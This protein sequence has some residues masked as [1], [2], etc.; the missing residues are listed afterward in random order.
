[1]KTSDS[2]IVIEKTYKVKPNILWTA[3][4][5]LDEMRKWYFADLDQFKPEI[6]SLSKFIVN[7]ED[8][9]YTH[10]WE[11]NRVIPQE[12]ISY[13]W[14]FSEHPGK[15]NTEFKIV[16]NE[17]DSKLILTMQILADFPSNVP[18]FKLES[19]LAGWEYFLG[20]QLVEFLKQGT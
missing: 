20:Q 11:V 4:T 12:L 18:E 19:C 1:M 6:G 3:L 9:V 16:K 15:S 2:P 10:M 8:R 13:S 14:Q 5:N 7:V 17:N